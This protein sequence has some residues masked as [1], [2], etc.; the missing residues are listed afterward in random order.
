MKY[1]VIFFITLVS[2]NPGNI[3]RESSTSM[4]KILDL[5]ISNVS[6]ID[7]SDIFFKVLKEYYNLLKEIFEYFVTIEKYIAKHK[8]WTD[9][10]NTSEYLK[11]KNFLNKEY[12][13]EL[14]KKINL[15][16]IDISTKL[17]ESK[18]FEM[19]YGLQVYYK[20][21]ESNLY[22]LTRYF[23]NQSFD[24]KLSQISLLDVISFN[25][26]IRENTVNFGSVLIN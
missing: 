6:E 25:R 15:L 16:Q 5:C 10:M 1:Y 17:P 18:Y 19:L 12:C 14:S 26:E 21:I 2:L 7:S 11:S 13:D 4:Y 20:N 22:H 23:I 8:F 24:I 3:E 9:T